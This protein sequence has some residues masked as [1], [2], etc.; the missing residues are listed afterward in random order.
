MDPEPTQD[1]LALPHEMDADMPEDSWAPYAEAVGK[2]ESGEMQRLAS[3]MFK[4][5][6]TICWTK[7]NFKA[8]EHGKANAHV[9]LYEIHNIRTGQPP[10]W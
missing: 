4:Q 8:S 3:D 10:C 9:R 7:E 6:G 5:A 1:S 2:I